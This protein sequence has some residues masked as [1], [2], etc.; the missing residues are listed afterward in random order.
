MFTGLL[1]LCEGIHR[2]PTQ[3]ASNAW[4]F[5]TVRVVSF[6]EKNKLLTKQLICLW[7]ETHQRSCHII[8]MRM[9]VS[10]TSMRGSSSRSCWNTFLPAG[11][12]RDSISS[13]TLEIHTKNSLRGCMGLLRYTGQLWD[14]WKINYNSLIMSMKVTVGWGFLCVWTLL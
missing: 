12:T 2:R 9:L 13:G 6:W 5:G 3:R 11:R 10:L 1:A 4:W 7:F 14:Q 8:V